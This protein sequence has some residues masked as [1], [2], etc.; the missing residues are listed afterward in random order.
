MVVKKE[1]Q[2]DTQLDNRQAVCSGG[3]S[4][5]KSDIETAARM[6]VEM[7]SRLEFGMVDYLVSL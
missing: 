3:G 7:E 1:S 6:E 5:A 2:R 4:A